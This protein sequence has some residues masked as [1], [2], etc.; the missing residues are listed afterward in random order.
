[1]TKRLLTE[2]QAF[3]AMFVFLEEYYSLTGADDIGALLGS[4]N[5]AEDGRPMDVAMLND[6]RRAVEVVM[7][8]SD[9]KS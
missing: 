1:M 2:M 5:L 6:W 8:N 7:K 3:E 9:R 4:L